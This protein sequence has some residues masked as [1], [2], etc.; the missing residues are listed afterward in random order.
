MKIL[1]AIYNKAKAQ[2]S[3]TKKLNPKRG[4]FV[5]QKLGK[6]EPSQFTNSNE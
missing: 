2:E 6:E 1:V 3:I 5:M 4:Y